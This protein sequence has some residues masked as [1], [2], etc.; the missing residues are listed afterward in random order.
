ML[1]STELESRAS[2]EMLR[3]KNRFLTELFLLGT[4]RAAAGLGKTV[5]HRGKQLRRTVRRA[6]RCQPLGEAHT[7]HWIS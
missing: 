5:F 1:S 6:V 7:W 4:K 3:L 2:D